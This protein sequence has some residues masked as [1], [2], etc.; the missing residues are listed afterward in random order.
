[1]FGGRVFENY[2]GTGDEFSCKVTAKRT[3]DENHS[4]R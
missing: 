1:M 2:L 4:A 3:N